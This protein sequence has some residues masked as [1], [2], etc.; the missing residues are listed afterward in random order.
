M[1]MDVEQILEILRNGEALDDGEPIDLLQHSLQCATLL[2][3]R[4]PG[5][6]ELQ[7]AGLLHD[8]GTVLR[9]RANAAHATIGAAAIESLLGSRVAWLIAH[10]VDAKRYLVA[11]DPEYRARL[12]ARSIETL[13]AQGGPLDAASVA[14]L[15]AHPDLAA[16][17]AL[18]KADDDAK[19]IGLDVGSVDRWIE[20]LHEVSRR[21]R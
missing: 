12:S 17:V 20:P 16:L 21:V 2:A 10:H 7:L 18:R 11:T 4:H 13:E 5:D 6:E 15:D 9:P 19:V 8:L 3:E 14:A 1:E